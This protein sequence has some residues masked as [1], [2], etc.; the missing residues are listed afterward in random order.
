MVGSTVPDTDSLTA[1]NIS[2]LI[3]R[4]KIIGKIWGRTQYQRDDERAIFAEI[5]LRE[6][7]GFLIT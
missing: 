6:P 7:K 2:L 4:K 5:G 1:S 3:Q